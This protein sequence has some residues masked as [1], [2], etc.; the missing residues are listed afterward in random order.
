MSYISNLESLPDEILLEICKYLLCVDVL[1]SFDNLNMRMT[2][3]ISNYRR[4]V[5]L[6]KASYAQSYKLCTIILPKIG[7]QIHTLCIDNC[8][9]AL[10][11]ISFPKYFQNRMSIC[12]PELQKLI[13]VS[14]RPD[15]LLIFLKI[16]NNLEKLFIIDIRSLFRV[17]TNQQTEVLLA[18]L[19]ANN[20]RLTSIYIDDQS[21]H[22][23][24]IKKFLS[25]SI[26]CPNIINLKIEISTICDLS[27]LFTILPNINYLSVSIHK[28]DN[29][30]DITRIFI[31]H[32]LIYL[33]KF[34]LKSVER[35]WYLKELMTLFDTLPSLKFLSLNLRTC[36]INLT[37]GQ[38][39]KKILPNTIEQFHYSI[40]YLPEQSVNYLEILNTW[41]NISPII[42]LYNSIQNDYMFLHTLPYLSFDYLEISS[43]VAES[44]LKNQNSYQH[45]QR[46]HVDCDFTLAEAFPIIGY[47]RKA[48]HSIIWLHGTDTNNL[49]N[50]NQ[51]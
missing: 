43:S 31:S 4:H 16:L 25:N 23:N 22:L 32:Q 47:C 28:K 49:D 41:K 10:Q 15:P 35:T 26:T 12:F 21:S 37:N 39:L 24:P 3:M 34:I 17:P 36:D 30:D 50:Q 8:Y 7:T 13:L 19:Q 51:G 20:Q 29:L 42:C 46:I 2:C 5:S 11:A 40:H 48:K 6:H 9:S 44:I 38:T 14:F 1:L 45:I 33:T 18:L 27:V